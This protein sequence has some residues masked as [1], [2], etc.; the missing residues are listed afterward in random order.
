MVPSSD[1]STY[2]RQ[3]PSSASGLPLF[4]DEA[5]SGSGLCGPSQAARGCGWPAGTGGVLTAVPARPLPTL[6]QGTSVRRKCRLLLPATAGRAGRLPSS[7]S[8]S[9]LP[10]APPSPG[11]LSSPICAMGRGGFTPQSSVTRTIRLGFFLRP[12]LRC[13]RVGRGVLNSQLGIWTQSTEKFCLES[14]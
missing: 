4:V 13:G 9:R 3:K 6:P 11:G 7:P 2:L 5:G 12:P 8:D 1:M 14:S 10:A